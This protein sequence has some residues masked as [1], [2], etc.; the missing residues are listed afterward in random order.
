MKRYVNVCFI[1]IAMRVDISSVTYIIQV[2][3][4]FNIYI[5][6][7]ITALFIQTDIAIHD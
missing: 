1:G 6:E 3:N 5:E 2:G 7:Y 4:F